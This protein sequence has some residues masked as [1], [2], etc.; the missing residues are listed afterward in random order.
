[1]DRIER[2]AI[3]NSITF[4]E[5]KQ[6][7]EDIT[8]DETNSRTLK[9]SFKNIKGTPQYM[10]NMKSDTIAKNRSFNVYTFFGTFTPAEAHW[11]EFPQIIA[12]QFEI[13]LTDEDVQ[14][15]SMKERH[16]W[17][18]QNPVTVVRHMDHN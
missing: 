11:L 17:L 6:F 1:M 12:R 4:F 2:V 8:A 5:R 14:N 10:S 18:K 15:M 7:Q 16:D 9:A 13:N 3:S